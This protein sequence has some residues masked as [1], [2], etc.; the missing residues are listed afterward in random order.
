MRFSI[1]I[2]GQ[3][4]LPGIQFAGSAENNIDASGEFS[5]FQEGIEQSPWRNPLI[6]GDVIEILIYLCPSVTIQR[7]SLNP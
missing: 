3:G 1:K 5:A 7:K 2:A 6:M 4:S